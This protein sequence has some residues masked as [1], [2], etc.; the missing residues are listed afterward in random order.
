MIKYLRYDLLA[1][2]SILVLSTG[3]KLQ[4]LRPEKGALRF[5]FIHKANGRILERDSSYLNPFGESYSISKLKYY[6]SNIHF[7]RFSE[8]NGYRLINALEDNSFTLPMPPGQY[9]ELSFMIGVDSARN[10]SGAQSGAL[11]PL[12]DMFWTWNSGYVMFKLEGNSPQS[13]ADINRIEH[14][15][16]GYKAPYKAMRY[17]V[18]KLE[19]P[20]VIKAG[21]QQDIIIEMNLDRY[22]DGTHP[23]KISESPLLMTIGDRACKMADNFPGMFSIKRFTE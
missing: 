16:G 3:F 2:F 19:R 1:V 4:P 17:V 8:L 5:H 15:I 22:W 21:Q 13:P 14:H 11:D 20:M 23:I 10:C 7:S 9:Q 18:L 6:V 12:N